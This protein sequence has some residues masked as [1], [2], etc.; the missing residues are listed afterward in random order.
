MQR[1]ALAGSYSFLGLSLLLA[2]AGSARAQDRG[3]AMMAGGQAVQ[4][5]PV[6][7]PPAPP[8]G[9]PV[10]PPGG[11]MPPPVIEGGGGGVIPP[12]VVPRGAAG[13]VGF[14]GN[15]G[16]GAIAVTPP[17]PIGYYAPVRPI[18]YNVGKF[19]YYPFYYYPHSYWPTESC[20]WPERPGEPYMRPPAYMTYP[21][22]IEPH[23]RHE[24]YTPQK[25]YRGFHFWLDQF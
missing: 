11:A 20:H 2:A 8:P 5:P 22:F 10:P 13:G 18:D 23:W 6:A 16:V 7:A 21:P 1:I 9:Q 3:G 4:P 24:W 19:F 17:P 15:L 14:V 25:Y 12:G